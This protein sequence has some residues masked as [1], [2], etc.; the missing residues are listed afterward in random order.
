[1]DRWSNGT[2]DSAREISLN[3]TY[4]KKKSEA[5]NPNFETNLNGRNSKLL[6]F[7]K[8]ENLDL[9]FVSDLD[10]RISDLKRRDYVRNRMWTGR[11]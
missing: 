9:E 11:G 5:R 3:C 1:M 10:I 4:D 7:W 2:I 6:T 8:F